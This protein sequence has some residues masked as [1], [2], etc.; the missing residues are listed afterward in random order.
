MLIIC[1]EVN[2][3]PASYSSPINKQPKNFTKPCI[4]QWKSCVVTIEKQVYTLLPWSLRIGQWIHLEFKKKHWWVYR[5][6]HLILLRC[7]CQHQPETPLV[8]TQY[9]QEKSRRLFTQYD[10]RRF[11]FNLKNFFKMLSKALNFHLLPPPPK[12]ACSD[13]EEDLHHQ[14]QKWNWPEFVPT[15]VS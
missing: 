1:P 3:T 10:I 11:F 12:H 15:Y 4:S 6:P 14:E 2:S 8:G 9:S 5:S 7:I 13:R